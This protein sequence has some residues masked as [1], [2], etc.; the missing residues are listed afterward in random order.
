MRQ[1]SSAVL[2]TPVLLAVGVA[3]V[4][5]ACGSRERTVVVTPEPG[6]TVVVTPAR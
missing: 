2:I 1:K 5:A 6:Q 4:L 3:F